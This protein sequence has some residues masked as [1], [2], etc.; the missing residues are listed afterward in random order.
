[1]FGLM[2]L[3]LGRLTALTA[4]LRY[5]HKPTGE[6]AAP[7]VINTCLPDKQMDWQESSDFPHVRAAIYQGAFDGVTPQ[8]HKV[9]IVCGIY[10]PG[11]VLDGTADITE[12]TTA[13]G[14]IVTNRS[15][16]PFVLRTPVEY[17][18]GLTEAGAEGLQPH[19][20]HF[21]KLYLEFLKT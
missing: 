21:S 3:L 15:F 12:L 5:L 17:T 2:N 19:P 11:S 10:T 1:M 13:I 6:M 16:P 14:G 20:Y 4:E 18:I 9:V 8:P 7:M